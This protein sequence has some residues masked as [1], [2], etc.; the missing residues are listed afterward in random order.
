MLL[1]LS[2]SNTAS[3]PYALVSMLGFE[4]RDLNVR[5]RKSRRHSLMRL[6][7]P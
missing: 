5:K 3:S 1:T 4:L 6:S 7:S 2:R